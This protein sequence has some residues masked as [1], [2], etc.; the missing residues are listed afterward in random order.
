MYQI[1]KA[2][3]GFPIMQF[4]TLRVCR[5]GTF[6]EADYPRVNDVFTITSPLEAITY[7][8]TAVGN[9]LTEEAYVQI[10]YK[11]PRNYE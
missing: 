2:E 8:V 11:E 9:P 1:F 4:T 5:D 3:T 7:V 6:V 10:S